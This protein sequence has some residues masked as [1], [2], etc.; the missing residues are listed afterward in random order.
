[1]MFHYAHHTELC[2]QRVAA[3]ITSQ[4]P[5]GIFNLS[6]DQAAQVLGCHPGH[7][8]NQLSEGTFPIATI[9]IGYRRFIPLTNLIDYLCELIAPA[10]P[11]QPQKRRRGPKSKAE[12]RVLREQ[13]VGMNG[14][15]A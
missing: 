1:M 4:L 5:Q 15:V 6:V 10:I 13:Q 3:D 14:G 9:A 8:R 12:K 7:I 11:D 2:R